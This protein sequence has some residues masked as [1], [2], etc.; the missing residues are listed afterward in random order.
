MPAVTSNIS[1]P[2]GAFTQNKARRI[3]DVS[4]A[5]HIPVCSRLNCGELTEVG[6]PPGEPISKG[7]IDL[8]TVR[9]IFRT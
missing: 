6:T 8:H 5:I 2:K 3:S 1:E 7:A 9:S 4:T